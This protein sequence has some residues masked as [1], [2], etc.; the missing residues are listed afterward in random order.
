LEFVVQDD[1]RLEIIPLAGSVRSLKGIVPKPAK[2]LSLAE[3]DDVI[4]KG[5]MPADARSFAPL[6]WAGQ[7]HGL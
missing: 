7:S 6:C 5:G 2:A 3:M 1:G 4:A